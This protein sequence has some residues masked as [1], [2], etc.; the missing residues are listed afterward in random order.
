MAVAALP[1]LSL[2]SLEA[3]V[4]VKTGEEFLCARIDLCGMLPA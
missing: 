3:Q 2:A 1:D 4:V